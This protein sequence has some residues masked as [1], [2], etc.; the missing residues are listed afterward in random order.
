MMILYHGTDI[1]SAISICEVNGISLESCSLHTDFGRGFYTTENYDRAMQWAYR[2]SI[3]RRKKPAIVKLT[4][5]MDAAQDIIE[6]FSDDL[7]WGRFIINNRNGLAYVRKV[8]FQEHNLDSRYEITSGR[9]ADIDV[10]TV[11]KQLKENGSMLMSVDSILNPL[12]PLQIAF[13]TEHALTFIVKK[14]YS[15]I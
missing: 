5:D 4:F 10:L 9:I 8:P 2:K 13:H 12:Y 14:T 7:R 3:V 1:D 11:A 15:C 6:Y